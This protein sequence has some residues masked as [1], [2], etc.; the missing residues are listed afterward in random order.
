MF[1]LKAMSADLKQYEENLAWLAKVQDIMTADL[2]ARKAGIPVQYDAK[3]LI[4]TM[5]GFP[6]LAEQM[7][8][9]YSTLPTAQVAPA[10]TLPANV[11]PY[12]EQVAQL[13]S[14]SKPHLDI[15]AGSPV[16]IPI[17]ATQPTGSAS[18]T[19]SS[20]G[21]QSGI[22]LADI[23]SRPRYFLMGPSYQQMPIF[24]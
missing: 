14:Q 21:L 1:T 19:V 23:T 16:R 20:L 9:I 22:T 5:T 13:L 2:A 4:D 6:K 8:Q 18:S 12:V 10:A 24:Q 3:S 11:R 15:G 17:S 7:T